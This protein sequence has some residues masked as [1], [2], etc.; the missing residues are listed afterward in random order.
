MRLNSKARFNPKTV[1]PITQT[2]HKRL[3]HTY[4]DDFT[5]RYPLKRSVYLW[6]S[7]AAMGVHKKQSEASCLSCFSITKNICPLVCNL[8]RLLLD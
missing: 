1:L 4:M 5:P 2:H 3:S 7:D 8:R 6:G